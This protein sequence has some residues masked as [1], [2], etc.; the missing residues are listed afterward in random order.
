MYW[1]YKYPLVIAIA[2][3]ALGIGYTVWRSL[4]ESLTARVLP[5]KAAAPDSPAVEVPSGDSAVPAP[6]VPAALPVPPREEPPPAVALP[7]VP[8]PAPAAAPVAVLPP[9]PAAPAAASRDTTAPPPPAP[10]PGGAAA[11]PE[12]A[13]LT[14]AARLLDTAAHQAAGG[15][16]LAAR[17]LA[18]RVL[19]LPGVVEFD[20]AW[21]AAAEVV[22]QVNRQFMSS[23]LAHPDRRAYTVQPG[24][25]LSRIATTLNTTVGALQ[26]MNGLDRD[27]KSVV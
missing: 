16:H 11:A 23:G 3:V 14:E 1:Y 22:D 15:N 10:A 19:G 25:S 8:A 24:D 5:A 26:R 2:L 4:P 12:V 9:G 18:A 17:E 27:R 20:R 13:P 21:F 7:P 6:P